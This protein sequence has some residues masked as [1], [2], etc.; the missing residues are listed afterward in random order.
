MVIEKKIKIEKIQKM[1]VQL[2]MK[3]GT[4]MMKMKENIM[5]EAM[6]NQNHTDSDS[7]D[8]ESSSESDSNLTSESSS[9]SDS[10]LSSE[11]SV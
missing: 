1:E 3:G 10:N 5:N 9:E 11:S 7:A 8:S 2:K 4:T 6:N